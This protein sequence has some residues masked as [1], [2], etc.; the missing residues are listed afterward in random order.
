[1]V[2]ME[3]FN[4]SAYGGKIPIIDGLTGKTYR[5]DNQVVFDFATT[6]NKLLLG[7]HRKLV[8]DEIKH[9]N[10]R[11]E[12][13]DKF[14]LEMNKITTPFGYDKFSLNRTDW[15]SRERAIVSRLIKKPFFTIR[16]LIAWD[17]DQLNEIAPKKPKSKYSD[18]INFNVETQAW[19]RR[20]SARWIVSFHRNGSRYPFHT[21][22]DQG[23]NLD[24]L[25][26][27][28]FIEQGLPGNVPSHAFKDV[29]LTYPIFYSD[30]NITEEELT[31]LQEAFVANLYFIY[32]PFSWI[33][34]RETRFRGGFRQDCLDHVKDER[35]YV[36]DRKWFDNVFSRFL[37]DVVTI[38]L[39]GA[40]E[41]Y[42]L[43]MVGKRFGE[44]PRA[45]GLGLDVLNWNKGEDREAQDKPEAVV[46][47]GNYK[48]TWG[49]RFLLI[50]AYVRHGDELT[51]RILT[52]LAAQKESRKKIDGK[53]M[54]RE[55]IEDISGLPYDEFGK[56]AMRTQEAALER[57]S[58]TRQQ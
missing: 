46:R 41:I 14:E 36:D 58:I 52:Q 53:A 37:S 39:Q 54:I 5:G 23:L 51:N 56:R 22:K 33:A 16:S 8:S 7:Y 50:D 42:S 9:M 6:F 18:D 4:V 43:H 47:L 17:L 28:H 45:L 10:F 24:T 26:G 49:I 55:I 48:S 38:K 40:E 12:L 19:E 2:M 25:H 34:R 3:A 13:G 44:S 21:Q 35:I 15:L 27:F 20:L 57:F 11:L 31:R 30:E 1:M 32:D 29:K